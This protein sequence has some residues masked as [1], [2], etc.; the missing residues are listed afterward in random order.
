[1]ID[2]AT[3]RKVL[4]KIEAVL[5]EALVE[6]QVAPAPAIEPLLTLDEVAAIHRLSPS[7]IRSYLQ[8]G[9]FHPQPVR[10]YPYR[11]LKSEVE[12]D[13]AT[14]LDARYAKHGFAA[15]HV[16]RRARDDEQR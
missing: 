11:W 3:I 9:L 7:T 5:R 6:V 13:L 1:M 2:D 14:H 16:R 15:K 8:K 4:V 12:R 10:K